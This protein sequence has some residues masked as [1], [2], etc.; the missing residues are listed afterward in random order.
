VREVIPRLEVGD[1]RLTQR[2]L[3]VQLQRVELLQQNA[4]DLRVLL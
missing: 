3:Q 2:F 4:L 1:V